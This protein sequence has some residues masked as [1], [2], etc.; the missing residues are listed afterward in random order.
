[1][2]ETEQT[3]FED[4]EAREDY[5]YQTNQLAQDPQYREFIWLKTYRTAMLAIGRGCRDAEF[6]ATWADDC[7]AAFDSRFPRPVMKAMDQ[8]L[9]LH[10][11]PAQY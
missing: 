2:T 4:K 11:R 10:L 5:L 6:A 7:L 1:M 8:T 9:A 3:Q